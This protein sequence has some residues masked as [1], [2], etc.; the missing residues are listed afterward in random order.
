M[1]Q[2]P[3]LK[4][5][6]RARCVLPGPLQTQFLPFQPCL[7]PTLKHPGL[8]RRDGVSLAACL[9]P[10]AIPGALRAALT[11]GHRA[12]LPGMLPKPRNKRNSLKIARAWNKLVFEWE[13]SPPGCSFRSGPRMETRGRIRMEMDNEGKGLLW[14]LP[15]GRDLRDRALP[16]MRGLGPRRSP[17]SAPREPGACCCLLLGLGQGVWICFYLFASLWIA[18]AFVYP[19]FPY[20]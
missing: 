17:S 6:G 4:S 11:P 16:L 13:S 18:M 14:L 1:P 9:A 3:Q 2:F 12:D 8:S 19:V 20:L 5:Q 10:A 7:S 15:E